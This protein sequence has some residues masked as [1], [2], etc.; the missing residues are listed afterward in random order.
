MGTPAPAALSG[1]ASYTAN[2]LLIGERIDVRALGKGERLATGP[3][4]LAVGG[5]VAVLFRFGAV[6]FFGVAEEE[7]RAF[8]GSL[9]PLV[10]QP[11]AEPE[12]ESIEVRIIPNGLE[13]TEGIEGNVL[14]LQDGTVERLQIVADVLAQSLVLS[15]YEARVAK[16]FDRVE[17]FAA[18]MAR[19]GYPVAG[20]RAVLQSIGGALLSEH[21]MVGRVE[22]GDKPD[23]LWERPDLE[24]LYGRLEDEFELA[25]RHAGLERKLDLIAST[26]HTFLELL[27]HR[28]A[29][30][31]EWYIVILIVF[32]IV[33]NLYE[34]IFGSGGL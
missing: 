27:Q 29:L 24:R 12:K 10:S 3:L 14:A 25:E 5:G 16:D 13:G 11:Y 1:K 4:A 31:V 8:L 34:K 19:T 22:I 30:R 15:L 18:K 9:G 23:L 20:M 28:H 2:A 33:L 26:A 6:V 21:R 17:P 7:A 32:E